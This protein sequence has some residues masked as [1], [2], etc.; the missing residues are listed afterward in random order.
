MLPEYTERTDNIAT[1]TFGLYKCR[2]A[3]LLLRL[4]HA[5]PSSTRGLML[6]RTSQ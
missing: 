5:L 3:Y 6:S 4:Q 2:F 1:Q